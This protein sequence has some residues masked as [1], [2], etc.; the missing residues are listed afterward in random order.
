MLKMDQVQ[1]LRHKV[2]KGGSIR[3]ARE[4]RLSRHTIAKY[5]DQ[6][7]PA[8]RSRRQRERP[9]WEAVHRGWRSWWEVGVRATAK[10]RIS[11]GLVAS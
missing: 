10:Q 4:L 7:E 5:L 6:A 8:R 3:V 1:V 9:V 11:G 2:P